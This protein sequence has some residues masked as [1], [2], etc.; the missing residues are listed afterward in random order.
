VHDDGGSGDEKYIVEAVSAGVA[1]FD[2]DGDGLIDI[3]FLSGAPLPPADQHPRGN[4]LY[5]NNGDGSFTNVTDA[6]G[7]GD[8]GFGLGVAVADF[9]NS[10]FPDIYLNNF[11]PNVLYRNN[12]D[13][14]FTDV[15]SEAGV[16]CGDQVGAGAA[17]L[18]AD[19][20]GAVDLYVSNYVD[21]GLHNHVRWTIDGFRCYPGPLDFQAGA[22][23]AVPQQRRR[24]VHRHQPVCGNRPGG[25]HGMG[26]VCGDFNNSG[27]TDIFVANDM[28]P[29]L[30]F[31][32]DGTGRFTEVSLSRG[33][34]F[35]FAG[36]V[37]G[38]M[39][40]DCG[41]FD[42]DGWLDLFTTS[43]INEMPVLYRNSGQAIVRGRYPGQWRRSR[44][45][46]ARELGNGLR[47]FQQQRAPR[48]VHRAGRT[49]P[50][51]SSLEQQNGFRV[52]QYVVDE[53]RRRA[54]H[55]RVGPLGD[56][57]TS[58]GAA[59]ARGSTT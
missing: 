8:A 40:V 44:I 15:T 13:G 26:M 42:N 57:C 46:T 22:R 53:H 24:D 5:R 16:D 31:E 9:D 54:V 27:A 6:A 48:P 20:D 37:N 29:N 21:F 18:D 32:N 36:K 39:G 19:G 56:G 3:Y 30:L 52:A 58:S 51:R 38:N 41:D 49:G 55:R 7:V 4:S 28:N 14:T 17:F 2:F 35:N 45:A 1:L 50:E 47:R 11:G 34:A 33:A 12:G 25:W 43:Y 10:G 23:R 59:A